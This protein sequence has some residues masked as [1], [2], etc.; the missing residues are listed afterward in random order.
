MVSRDKM[1][2]LVGV[3]I[4]SVVFFFREVTLPGTAN[5]NSGTRLS[6]QRSMNNSWLGGRGVGAKCGNASIQLSPLERLNCQVRKTPTSFCTAESLDDGAAIVHDPWPIP[7]QCQGEAYDAFGRNLTY[8]RDQVVRE[9][10][11]RNGAGDYTWSRRLYGLPSSRRV[12]F[13]GNA[14]TW[15]MGTAM[16]CQAASGDND[17][18][19]TLTVLENAVQVDFTNNSTLVMY[20]NPT[21]LLEDDWQALVA[22][23]TGQDD[24]LTSFDA[25]IL[26]LFNDC[27]ALLASHAYECESVTRI[28]FHQIAAVFDGPVLFVSEMAATRNDESMQVRDA[29]RGFRDVAGRKNMWFIHGRRYISKMKWEGAVNDELQTDDDDDDEIEAEDGGTEMADDDSSSEKGDDDEDDE[30]FPV[31][32]DTQDVYTPPFDPRWNVT[33]ALNEGSKSRTTPRC[34]GAHGGHADLLAWDI[35]EFIYAQ[36]A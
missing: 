7:F 25:V 26:G 36:L 1:E 14:H 35:S 6:V 16:A 5:P 32:L 23:E 28:F 9:A 8:F 21:V 30:E 10:H 11:D 33:V 13:F 2:T 31:L 15:Q 27:T 34:T 24:F 18:I 29:I 20:S 3:I 19:A 4:L 12:L 22:E 17:Q